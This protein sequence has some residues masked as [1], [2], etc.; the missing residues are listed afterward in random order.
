MILHLQSLCF[1]Y[2]VKYGHGSKSLHN[3]TIV[4]LVLKINLD[5]QSYRDISGSSLGTA[6]QTSNQSSEGPSGIILQHFEGTNSIL[7]ARVSHVIHNISKNS[8]YY[9][10]IQDIVKP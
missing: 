6:M 1:R 9:Y 5:Y 2:R 3:L 10:L 8:P 7:T 4:F